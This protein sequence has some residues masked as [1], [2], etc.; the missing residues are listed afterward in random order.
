MT[1]ETT[2]KHGSYTWAILLLAKIITT[3]IL[4]AHKIQGLTFKT[5]FNS[6]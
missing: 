4:G 6:T 1:P 2:L 5:A 3:I